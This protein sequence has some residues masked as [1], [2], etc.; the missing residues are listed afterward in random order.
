MWIGYLPKPPK[1]LEILV[2]F[3]KDVLLGGLKIWN[4]NKSIIDCTKGVKDV[5]ILIN[6]SMVWEGSLLSGKGQVNVEYATFIV[7]KDGLELT[8]AIEVKSEPIE[9]AIDEVD[10]DEESKDNIQLREGD[11]KQ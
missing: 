10:E 2:Y 3:N 1:H 9:E 11:Y 6:D 8:N 5:Q 4:Y 7:L